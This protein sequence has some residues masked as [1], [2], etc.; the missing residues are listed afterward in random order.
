MSRYDVEVVPH[1]ICG[2]NTRDEIDSKLDN[3][4]FMGIRN[5]VALRGDSTLGEKRFT[6]LPEGYRYAS[7]LVEGIRSYKTG[8]EY[9][10]IGVGGYPEKHFEAPNLETDIANLKRKVDIVYAYS[11]RLLLIIFSMLTFLSEKYLLI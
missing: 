10:C 4:R 11:P 9:F 2:G 6:P 5:L 8:A 1:L 7:E 3:L